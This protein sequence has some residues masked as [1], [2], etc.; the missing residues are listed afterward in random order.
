MGN[1]AQPARFDLHP[2]TSVDASDKKH[3]CEPL[4]HHTEGST[5]VGRGVKIKGRQTNVSLEDA[6]WNGLREISTN[7]GVEVGELVAT[8]DAERRFNN[9]SSAIRVFVLEYYMVQIPRRR[10]SAKQRH[11]AKRR[12]WPANDAQHHARQPN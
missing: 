9:L 6:F 2:E 4:D 12:R 7:R 10:R 1:A 3:A 11:R 8:I 5:I